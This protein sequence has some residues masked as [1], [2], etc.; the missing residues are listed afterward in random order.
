MPHIF[1]GAQADDVAVGAKLAGPFS[2]IHLQRALD[3]CTSWAVQ[4]GARFGASKSNVLLFYLQPNRSLHQ[5][6][7]DIASHSFS[8]AGHENLNVRLTLQG[9]QMEVKDRYRYLGVWLSSDLSP[10][11]QELQATKA[12]NVC[13]FLIYRTLFPLRQPSLRAVRTLILSFLLPTV[14]YGCEFWSPSTNFVHLV[15][16][17]L[18]RLLSLTMKIPHTAHHLSIL[19]E[20]K[21]PP[22]DLYRHRRIYAVGKRILLSHDLRLSTSE[23][24]AHI[25]SLIPPPSAPALSHPRAA[26][27]RAE[28]AAFFAAASFA[29]FFLESTRALG[30]GLS[31]DAFTA[32][33]VSSLSHSL[34]FDASE[35]SLT[36][37]HAALTADPLVGRTL[38]RVYAELPPPIRASA[39]R[40]SRL[41]LYLRVLPHPLSSLLFAARLNRIATADRLHTMRARA[42][43]ACTAD[44]LCKSSRT[45]Q[46]LEHVLLACPS[47]ASLRIQLARSLDAL[48]PFAPPPSLTLSLTLGAVDVLPRAI[49]RAALTA[50]AQFVHDAFAAVGVRIG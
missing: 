23:L 2:L 31:A 32:T 10:K 24:K 17:R 48:A 4:W 39:I 42:D 50:V 20:C 27:V 35:R 43:A 13:Y 45:S 26:A 14:A 5:S 21:I 37:L 22:F 18:C 49:Q 29:G 1:V 41:P 30:I 47:T 11:L 44:A 6:I 12:L 9:F 8:I 46:T 15:N 7:D 3:A 40:V 16:R 34:R 25:S 38:Q 33:A 36:A 28:S 19:H